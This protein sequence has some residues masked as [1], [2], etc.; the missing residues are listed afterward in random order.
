MK[1][2]EPLKKIFIPLTTV[3]VIVVSVFFVLTGTVSALYSDGSYGECIYSASCPAAASQTTP[4]TP[5]ITPE[6]PAEETPADQNQATPLLTETT[7]PETTT[8]DPAQQATLQRLSTTVL[9]AVDAFI[10]AVPVGQ[11]PAVVYYSWLLL[12]MLAVVLLLIAWFDRR[13]TTVLARSVEVLRRTMDEQK[14]FLRIVLHYLNTPLATT[15]NSLELLERLPSEVAAVSALKPASLDLDGAINTAVSE[16]TDNPNAV[17]ANSQ[18]LRPNF[19]YVLSRWYF[20]VPIVIAVIIGVLLNIGLSR[21]GTERPEYYLLQQ[22]AIA[23]VVVMIFANSLRI[24]KVTKYQAKILQAARSSVEQLGIKRKQIVVSLS[25]SLGVAVGKIKAGSA[26]IHDTRLGG[27]MRGGVATLEE[28]TW[29]IEASAKPLSL[30]PQSCAIPALVT[31]VLARRQPELDAKNLT[32]TT[33][34]NVSRSTNVYVPELQLMLDSII[35]NAIAYSKPEGAIDISA[36]IH[37]GQLTL[38][39]QDSGEGMDDKQQAK[40]FKPFSQ[41]EDVLTYDHEGMGLSLYVSKNIASRLHGDI[42]IR[43]QKNRGTTASIVVPVSA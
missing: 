5:A 36:H 18:Q 8:P 40:L 13:R 21:V 4:D 10:E 31:S 2:L 43:S 39:V 29:K 34:Y 38:A 7:V 42:T 3:G 23:L 27:F 30:S 12:I 37:D 11:R 35:E 6:T 22:A 16:V 32:V 24:F 20:L 25:D 28:L 33:N 1:I 19:V 26:L 9:S 41:T 14:N 15:K 17:V